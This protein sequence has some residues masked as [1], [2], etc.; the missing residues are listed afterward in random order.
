[1][2][3][4]E[5]PVEEYLNEIN[6]SKVELEAVGFFIKKAVDIANELLAKGYK[7]EGISTETIQQDNKNL[8]KIKIVM[9]K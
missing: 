7:I 2:L 3:I 4:Q 8:S 5:K 9:Q 1:M 6:E